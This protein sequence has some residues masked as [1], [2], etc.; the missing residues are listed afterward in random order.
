MKK[1]KEGKVILHFIVFSLERFARWC[2]SY[3]DIVRILSPDAL[4]NEVISLLNKGN[5]Y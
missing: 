1:I 3:I 2:L 4:K 5:K